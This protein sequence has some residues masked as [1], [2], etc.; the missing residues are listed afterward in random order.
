M[1]SARPDPVVHLELHTGN[2]PRACAFY[3]RLL[4]WRAETV[5]VGSAAYVALELGGAIAGGVVEREIARPLW[6]P[7]A[8]VADVAAVAERAVTLGATVTLA[9][10]EGP[11]GWRSVVEAPAGGE[12]AL[13][14]PKA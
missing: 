13:W 1:R 4:G 10:R 6:L 9:P 11:T 5:H 12:L 8:E 2:L 7:Y 14:Q 3:A